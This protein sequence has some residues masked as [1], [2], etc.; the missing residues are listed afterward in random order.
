M[1][2]FVV[3]FGLLSSACSLELGDDETTTAEAESPVAQ[4]DGEQAAGADAEEATTEEATTEEA[5]A[6]AADVDC[7]ALL[8]H[9]Q[10]YVQVAGL[11]AVAEEPEPLTILGAESFDAAEEAVAAFRPFQDVEPEVFGP[12]REGLDNMT[13]D[14]P[15]ARDGSFSGASG[16]YGSVRIIPVLEALG[17]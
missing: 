15:S 1:V 9:R 13:A 2:A 3:A 7:E 10:V 6:P 8:V 12:L 5:A 17:C 11:M 14:L 16:N 4:A